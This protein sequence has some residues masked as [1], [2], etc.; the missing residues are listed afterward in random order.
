M[1]N[2]NEKEIIALL[3]DPARQREAFE[4]IVKDYS[5]QLY[6]QVRRLVFSHEDAN[7]ICDKIKSLDVAPVFARAI[8]HI[9]GGTSIADLF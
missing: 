7:D 5:E 6:W 4:A 8:S 2:Y 3:Q 1:N 9:H